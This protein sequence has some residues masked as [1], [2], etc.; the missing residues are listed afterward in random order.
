MNE[1]LY[2]NGSVTTTE[3]PTPAERTE[4]WRLDNPGQNYQNVKRWRKANPDFTRVE[5]VRKAAKKHGNEWSLTLGEWREIVE[6]YGGRCAYCL[7]AP[8]EHLDHIIPSSKG[9]PGT[10]DNV[11]PACKLCNLRKASGGL[12]QRDGWVPHIA[13]RFWPRVAEEMYA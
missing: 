4:Q 12:K 3:R 10:K 6:E 5:N 13:S 1:K 9:G 7:S 2:K 8:Y 11:V